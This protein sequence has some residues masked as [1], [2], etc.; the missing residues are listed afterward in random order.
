MAVDDARRLAG[1]GDIRKQACDEPGAHRRP[2]QRRND[3]LRAIDHVVDEISCLAKDLQGSAVV[4]GHCVEQFEAAARRKAL[5]GPGQQG[6]P[7]VRVTVDCG[8]HVGKPVLARI[9]R[10][11]P[12]ALHR[13]LQD[14]VGRV[15][16]AAFQTPANSD[17]RSSGLLDSSGHLAPSS[18]VLWIGAHAVLAEIH[19]DT[20]RPAAYRRSG[21]LRVRPTVPR[22]QSGRAS[23][24]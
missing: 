20:G 19:H 5:A 3:R 6:H 4:L 2:P 8:P 14:P 16:E 10:V 9:D 23:R 17:R 1:D 13:D 22:P 11:E 15:R 24:R 21:R 7:Y 18:E 12:W